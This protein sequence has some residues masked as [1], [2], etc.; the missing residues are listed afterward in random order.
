MAQ[1]YHAASELK[2]EEFAL[3]VFSSLMVFRRL[4]I[5]RSQGLAELL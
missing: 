5:I 2:P 4:H 3:I 1:L